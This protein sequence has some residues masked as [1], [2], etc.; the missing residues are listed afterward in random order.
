MFTSV[1]IDIFA[2]EPKFRSFLTRTF[3]SVSLSADLSYLLATASDLII[4]EWK[5]FSSSSSQSVI[6][7][8]RLFH[9]INGA[10]LRSSCH[11]RSRYRPDSDM[12]DLKRVDAETNHHSLLASAK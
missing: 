10:V 3:N 4:C 5:S 11:V 2:V 6:V 1:D 9:S 7:P 12:I 8:K